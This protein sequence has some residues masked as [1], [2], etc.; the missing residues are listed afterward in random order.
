MRRTSQTKNLARFRGTSLLAA[1]IFGFAFPAVAQ[2]PLPINLSGY[3]FRLGTPCTI[4]GEAGKCGVQFGGWTGGGGQEADGWTPF[5][6]NRKGLWEA[7]VNYT[8]APDFGAT[9][10][11]KSGSFDLLFKHGRPVSGTVTGGMV[12]WPQSDGDL[13]C[14]TA[15]AKVTV[16]LTIGGSPHSFDGCLHDLPAGTIIPPTIWGVLQ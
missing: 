16:Y 5:P 4:N 14:G 2:A 11:L 6:G 12:Q 15:V 13:G 8:G 3:E 10:D 9:V 7:E 1:M